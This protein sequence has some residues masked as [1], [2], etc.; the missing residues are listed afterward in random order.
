MEGRRIKMNT[1]TPEYKEWLAALNASFGRKAARETL[2]ARVI[3]ATLEKV[4]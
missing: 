2:E 3:K 1:W 4:G